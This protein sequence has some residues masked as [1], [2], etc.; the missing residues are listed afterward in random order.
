M[1]RATRPPIINKGETLSL[2]PIAVGYS[3]NTRSTVIGGLPRDGAF[4]CCNKY[5]KTYE[6]VQEFYL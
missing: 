6:Y 3:P 4:F 2:S 1:G 5:K